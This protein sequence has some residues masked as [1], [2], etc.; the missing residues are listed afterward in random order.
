MSARVFRRGHHFYGCLLSRNR[1]WLLG[2]R[3]ESRPDVFGTA[4][5][6]GRFVAYWSTYFSKYDGDIFFM[7]YV[8]D[9]RSGQVTRTV[10]EEYYDL[11][12]QP[13]FSADGLTGL[14]LT[15]RGEAG[16]ILR[17]PRSQAPRYVV[18]VADGSPSGH[19]AA[20]IDDS[21]LVD[22]SSLS[23]AGRELSWRSGGAARSY[24]FV[25]PVAPVN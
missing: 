20:R 15:T 24:S 19:A 9:L 13:V 11:R 6:A 14:L 3:D 23:L 8:R 21:G 18:E 7:I 4:R 22:G 12:D 2:V 5:L 17:D 1:P 10:H 25:G 16:W